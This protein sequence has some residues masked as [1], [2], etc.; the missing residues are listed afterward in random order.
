MDTKTIFSTDENPKLP[1][2]YIC[3]TCEHRLLSSKS[4][5]CRYCI[6]RKEH[7]NY[8]KD[9]RLT[10]MKLDQYPELKDYVKSAM[11]RDK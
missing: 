6:F 5:T 8:K 4:V 10:N 7:P 11:L 1:D 3:P 9:T 2:N